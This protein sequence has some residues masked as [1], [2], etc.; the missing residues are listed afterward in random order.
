MIKSL[1]PLVICGALCAQTD[2]AKLTIGGDVSQP[3]VLTIDD[4][5]K[6]PRATAE[7]KNEQGVEMTYR[8]VLLYEILKRAGAPVDKQLSGKTLATY[9][10][11]EARDGYKVVYALPEFDPAFTNN[12]SIVADTMNDKPLPE[13]LGPFRLVLPNEK[14]AARSVRMLEKITIVR[15]SK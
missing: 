4:L 3:L 9:I 12:S 13:N 7:L 2:P 15:L 5:G 10:L 11:A 8:G 14:K 6:M 1:L